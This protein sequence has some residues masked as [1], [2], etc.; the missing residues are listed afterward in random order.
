MTKVLEELSNAIE[1]IIAEGEIKIKSRILDNVFSKITKCRN[2]G[3][4]ISQIH[5]AIVLSG[6]E[7]SLAT[8]RL[9]L[10]RRKKVQRINTVIQSRSSSHSHETITKSNEGT[11]RD[12]SEQVLL[13]YPDLRKKR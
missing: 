2:A 11:Y 13:K 10:A 9:Y 7:I 4:T 5:N 1:T 12:N 6:M 3:C 8:F